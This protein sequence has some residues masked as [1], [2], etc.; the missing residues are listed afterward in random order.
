MRTSLLERHGPSA[1]AALRFLS[2]VAVAATVFSPFAAIAADPYPAKPV[3][4]I[5]NS[6]PGG[7]TDVIARLVTTRMG[8]QM[9][10]TFVAENRTGVP[11]VGADALAKAAPDGYTIGVLGNSVSAMPAMFRTLPFNV[12]NDL[13]PVAL[14]ITVPL[15]MDTA[16]NSPYKTVADFVADAK[17]RPGQV[18]FASGGNA[19]MSHLLPEQ[20]QLAAGLKLVHVPYK[21]GAPAMNDLMAG[22]VPVFF[23]TLGTTVP[24][25]QERKI[26]PLAIVAKSRAPQLPDVPTMA[27]AG[28]PDVEGA[29]WFAIFAPAGTPADVVARLNAEANKALQ[30][31]EL[32]ERLAAL[33]CTVE[34]GPPKVL[35]DLM[36][37]E[38]PR[39]TRLI[40]ERNIK[41]E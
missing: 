35:A 30:T 18:A 4:V 34:G 39:W 22:H 26:R 24:L 7:L 11:V 36:K 17:A 14:L 37:T 9:A 33:G 29:S 6:S 38:S 27:E 3:R 5:I 16:I 20:F 40:R 2:A 8:Q 31:P 10:Q 1:V 21:G 32:K 13:M 12:E 19:T 25:A 28:Y 41:A 15:V 23:D